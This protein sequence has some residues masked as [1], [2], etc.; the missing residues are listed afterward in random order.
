MET[1]TTKRHSLISREL[2][3]EKLSRRIAIATKQAIHNDQIS[4]SKKFI[5]FQKGKNIFST[6]EPFKQYTVDYPLQD[7]EVFIESLYELKL[8]LEIAGGTKKEIRKILTHEND[9][10]VKAESLL[11]GSH[12]GYIITLG[13]DDTGN[14][15]INHVSSLIGTPTSMPEIEYIDFYINVISAPLSS[16]IR[17][18]KTDIEELDILQERKKKL[19]KIY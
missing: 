11:S 14:V 6:S 1:T 10:S 19:E 8:A 13:K 4:H 7:G 12:L 9:H 3:V 5:T 18:S 2:L 17:L 15:S 16:G